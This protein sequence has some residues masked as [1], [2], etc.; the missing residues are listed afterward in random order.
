MTPHK[1]TTPPTVQGDISAALKA[2][3]GATVH[4]DNDHWHIRREGCEEVDW[5]VL[6]HEEEVAME[7]RFVLR[8]SGSDVPPEASLLPA[9]LE[10]LGFKVSEA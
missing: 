2:N 4:L 7:R 9:C 5:D 6:S 3:P 10:M 8:P 1:P